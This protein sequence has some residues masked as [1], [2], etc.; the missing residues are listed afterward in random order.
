MTFELNST[1]LIE[2]FLLLNEKKYFRTLEED[3]PIC[4][5]H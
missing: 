3:F 1:T 4:I 5:S 2:Q